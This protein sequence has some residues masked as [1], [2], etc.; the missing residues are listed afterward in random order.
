MVKQASNLMSSTL[1]ISGVAVEHLLFLPCHVY[2]KDKKSTYLGYNDYGTE[3]LGFKPGEIAGHSDF[4]IF[5]NYIAN[6]FVNNDRAVINQ[7][8]QVFVR[9]E[10]L[11]KKNVSV[12]FISYKIPVFDNNE[13]V[14]G[15]LG[16]SFTRSP[17]NNCSSTQLEQDFNYPVNMQDKIL[18]KRETE[19]MRYLCK[20]LTTKQI[21]RQLKISPKTVETYIERAKIKYNCRNKAELMWAMI[22]K[23][24]ME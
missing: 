13:R 10:G 14:T 1:L 15:I 11:L 18:S 16:L 8:K 22:K 17:Q 19:C 6:E 2:L 23:F 3:R 20:G 12:T 24:S 21:A 9:E 5:P 7:K 4:E